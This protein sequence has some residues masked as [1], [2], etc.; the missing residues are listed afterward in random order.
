MYPEHILRKKSFETLTD[1]GQ[2]RLFFPGH[3]ML[4]KGF[5]GLTL[6]GQDRRWSTTSTIPNENGWQVGDTVIW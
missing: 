5:E 2:D 4:K 6:A 1:T 3:V